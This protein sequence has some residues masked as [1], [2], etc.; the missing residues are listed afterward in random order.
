MTTPSSNDTSGFF[1]GTIPS[2][3][4][5]NHGDA[6]TGRVTEK[7]MRQQVNFETG[8]LQFWPDGRAKMM[9]VLTLQTDQV[10]D[11]DP[12]LRRLFVRGLMQ[13][14]FIDAVKASGQR[15]VN[16]GDYV[17]VEY[18]STR[19]PSRKGLEG[20]KEFKAQVSATPF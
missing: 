16:V 17:T 2:V 15:D 11:E 18:V 10:T 19:E 20:A 12:G 8:A 4:F 7:E 6:V 14:A 1:G 13:P 3:E 9:V 5:S